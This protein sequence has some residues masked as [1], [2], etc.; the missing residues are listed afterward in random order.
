G[1]L[2][3][4]LVADKCPILAVVMKNVHHLRAMS[5]MV[6]E[7]LLPAVKAGGQPF[8]LLV[9]D[10]EADDGSILD[11]RVESSLDPALD[12]L[13]QIPRAIVDLWEAR[14]HTGATALSTLYATYVGY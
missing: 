8:H 10:D 1:S 2:A 4:R 13:K 6:R 11:A 5:D 9:V 3:R 12:D 14:P 7:Q